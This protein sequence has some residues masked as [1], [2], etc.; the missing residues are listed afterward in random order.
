MTHWLERLNA[1]PRSRDAVVAGAWLVLGLAA[2]Q[3]GGFALW[4]VAAILP[5]DGLAF[6]LLLLAMAALATQ[7]SRH[8]FA[9]LA[10]GTLLTVTDL[11]F[12]GSIGVIVIFTDLLYAAVRYGSDRGVRVLLWI[13]I[14]VAALTAL[15]LAILRPADQ[16][17]LVIVIQ[18]AL[19][20]L[21][22]AVWGWNVRSEH[23]RTK[24]HMAQQHAHATQRLR[25][26]I[27]HD[28]HDLVANQI[29]V[30][31]LHVEAAKLQL[32]RAEV[33]LP[34]VE[35]SLEQA[36]RGTDEADQQLRRMIS[37][38]NAL[39]DLGEQ[40]GAPVGRLLD[41]FVHDAEAGMPGS[42]ALAWR[43]AGVAGLRTALARQ[44]DARVRV[45]LR[46]LRELLA[47]AVKHGRGTVLVEVDNANGLS[48][49]VTND[50][51]S[52]VEPRRGN[53]IG[54]AG[55]ALLLD[56]S[57]VRLESGA[58]DSGTRWRATLSVPTTGAAS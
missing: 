17:V 53:G 19:I 36:A 5:S 43:G 30:A 51:A 18:W 38:L 3:L 14:A 56:G 32:E 50:V 35:R 2:L 41:D 33:T 7:R 49:A 25:R 24:A 46:V 57:G 31:G 16:A 28:L 22:A 29:A 47:N 37:L 15:T 40:E 4:G 52:G 21:I 6:L 20:V 55:A 27:A 10:A 58:T 1:H 54:I 11:L 44:P 23:L 9:V 13:L 34:P 48:V 26:T 45:I 42:R 39:D 12:G 8:P